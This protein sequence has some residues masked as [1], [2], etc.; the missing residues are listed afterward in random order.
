MSITAILGY[1]FFSKKVEMF[2]ERK[3]FNGI[4]ISSKDRSSTFVFHIV[5][6]CKILQYIWEGNILIL[7]KEIS[8][9]LLTF[10]HIISLKNLYYG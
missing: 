4:D 9:I 5:S 10:N 8:Q 1:T 3:V 7:S 6:I 2:I